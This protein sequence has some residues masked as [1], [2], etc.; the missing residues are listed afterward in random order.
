MRASGG[1]PT[2]VTA[3]ARCSQGTANDDFLAGPA[4]SRVL[5]GPR[6]L[7]VLTGLMAAGTDRRDRLYEGTRGIAHLFMECRV[8]IERLMTRG[9][10]LVVADVAIDRRGLPCQHQLHVTEPVDERA[11]QGARA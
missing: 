5:F 8:L 4:L 2:K 1:D 9:V 7:Q 6:V 11:P 3:D 10:R